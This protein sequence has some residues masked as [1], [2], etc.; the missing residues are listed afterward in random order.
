MNRDNSN[1][2]ERSPSYAT[3]CV[4]AMGSSSSNAF[5]T[6]MISPPPG[7]P[8]NSMQLLKQ[9]L[10]R[11]ALISPTYRGP[12]WRVHKKSSTWWRNVE[13]LRPIDEVIEV[14]NEDD[15]YGPR[16]VFEEPDADDRWARFVDDVH[17]Q[18]QTRVWTPTAANISWELMAKCQQISMENAY[19]FGELHSKFDSDSENAIARYSFAD[20]DRDTEQVGSFDPDLEDATG[21][22]ETCLMF[23]SG[24]SESHRIHNDENDRP[25]GIAEVRSLFDES[26]WSS[27][28]QDGSESSE[29][30]EVAEK[31]GAEHERIYQLFRH[32]PLCID[33]T[34]RVT[35][36]D[37]GYGATA[38]REPGSQWFRIEGYKLPRRIREYLA[39]LSIANAQSSESNR[40]TGTSLDS[41]AHRWLFT[42][43]MNEFVFDMLTMT[44]WSRPLDQPA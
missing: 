6:R 10:T 20:K 32:F 21:Q 2:G 3:L 26:V 13:I 5:T 24:S 39:D 4:R 9:R 40:N 7:F 23:K 19:H 18:R 25:T 30:D 27:T 28:E 35:S 12:S 29:D 15:R 8:A 44:M 16:E 22:S 43:P 37:E 31:Y 11:Q 34:Q 33:R 41:D 14:V 36:L 17:S 1:A 42:T 38:V